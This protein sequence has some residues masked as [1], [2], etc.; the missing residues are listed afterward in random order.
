MKKAKEYMTSFELKNVSAD[1]LSEF[2]DKTRDCVDG[3]SE[4][5]RVEAVV[6]MKQITPRP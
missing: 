5:V 3:N 2:F 1:N 6:V 4:V